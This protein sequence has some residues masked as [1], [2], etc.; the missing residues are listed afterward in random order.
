MDSLAYGLGGIWNDILRSIGANSL[1]NSPTTTGYILMFVI[2]G[3]V[4]SSLGALPVANNINKNAASEVNPPK[5][6][7]EIISTSKH[8]CDHCDLEYDG[9]LQFCPNCELPPRS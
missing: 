8:R 1:T 5:Q 4:F 3:I 9:K 6:N 7:R 2:V